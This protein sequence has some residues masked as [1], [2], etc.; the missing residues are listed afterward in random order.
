MVSILLD[1]LEEYSITADKFIDKSFGLF[2]FFFFV[3]WF[4]R[5]KLTG[6][7]VYFVNLIKYR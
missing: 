3:Y 4:M 5:F 6:F 1:L 7:M 2:F